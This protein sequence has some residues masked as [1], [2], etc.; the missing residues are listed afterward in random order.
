[1]EIKNPQGSVHVWG[2][3]GMAIKVGR[4]YSWEEIQAGL[5]MCN[6][7][8]AHGPTF[9]FSFAGRCCATCLPAMRKKHEYP[10]WTN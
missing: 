10:G 4:V 7:C 5:T 3:D 6:E 9:R 8:G 1:M 2:A